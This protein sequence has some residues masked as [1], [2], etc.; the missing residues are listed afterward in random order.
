MRSLPDDRTARAK[1][2]D[3]ALRLFGERGPDAVTVR[4]IAAAAGVSPALVIRHYGSKDGLREAVDEH[5]TS[6]FEAVLTRA[7]QAGGN[8][9]FDQA[10]LPTLAE[11]MAEF[12][13][14]DSPIPGYLGRLLLAAGPVGT[15][16]FRRLHTVSKDAL[17]ALAQAGAAETGADP[18]VR[19]A[20]LLVNDLAVLILRTRLREVLG[21]DPLS[22]EGMERW[23]AETLSI[24]RTG[25]GGNTNHT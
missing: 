2:R 21:V 24:Y 8:G 11:A 23:A 4:D 10:A 13:P 7:V 17:A 12:L 3:E 5:V 25:L 16:L 18:E 14:A 22:G 19:A 20:F 9:P 1:I 6:V 15:A